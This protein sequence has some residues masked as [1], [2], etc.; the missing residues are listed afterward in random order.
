MTIAVIYQPTQPRPQNCP[1]SCANSGPGEQ[2]CR[3]MDGHPGPDEDLT[4]SAVVE[5]WSGDSPVHCPGWAEMPLAACDRHGP[6]LVALGCGRCDAE[7]LP[8]AEAATQRRV[9]AE[10]NLARATVGT[11]SPLHVDD[12]ARLESAVEDAREAERVAWDR[13]G[14]GRRE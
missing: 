11:C 14:G 4:A 8:M 13:V 2:W 6:Y 1:S 10:L 9:E 7:R 12:R 3:L 5:A